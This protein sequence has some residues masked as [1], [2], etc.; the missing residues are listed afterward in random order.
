[1]TVGDAWTRELLAEL[2]AARFSPAGWKRF[3]GSSLARAGEQRRSRPGARR[4]ALA[5]AVLGL[6]AWAVVAVAGHPV[7]AVVGAAWWLLVALMLWWHLGLLETPEGRSLDRLG[8]SNLVSLGRAAVIP[9]LP[10]LSPSLLAGALVAA[11]ATDVLDGTLARRRREVTRL[12]LWLDGTVDGVLVGVTAASLGVAGALPWWGAGLV[13]ARVVLPWLVAPVWL[14][15]AQIPRHYVSGRVPGAVLIAGLF[16]AAVG[17]PA[18]PEIVAA[19]AVGGI[20]CVL[21]TVVAA[22]DQLDVESRSNELLNPLPAGIGNRVTRD[23][24]S[25]PIV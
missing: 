20:A 10:A 9:A 15:S 2:R 5:T 8:L 1:M 23:Q 21:L 14:V 24:G 19:G 22:C 11:V 13:L 6:A 7:L 3:F 17:L 16:A 4:E 12:G 25:H 18:A